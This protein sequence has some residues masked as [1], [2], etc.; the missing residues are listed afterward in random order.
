[1]TWLWVVTGLV[2]MAFA[3]FLLREVLADRQAAAT[4]QITVAQRLF[5]AE[6]IRMTWYRLAI[7]TSLTLAGFLPA[8]FPVEARPV[9]VRLSTVV[10]LVVALV[11][12]T[13]D[14]GLR[15]RSKR[16]MLG[17]LRRQHEQEEARE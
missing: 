11:L 2:G 17:Q 7:I 13:V 6:T 9:W 10:L 4:R 5:L 12:L 3:G 14:T 15:L 8:L 16:R 1:M